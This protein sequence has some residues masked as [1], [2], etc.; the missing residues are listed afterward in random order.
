MYICFC[1]LQTE[2]RWRLTD[3]SET[4]WKRSTLLAIMFTV[5]DFQINSLQSCEYHTLCG[6]L[7]KTQL[8]RYIQQASLSAA[9]TAQLLRSQFLASLTCTW[10]ATYDISSNTCVAT[11]GC[12]KNTRLQKI[13][14]PFARNVTLTE[15]SLVIL[16][17]NNM[18]ILEIQLA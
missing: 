5:V 1:G 16:Q 13:T 2:P 11:K 6:I 14:I 15:R 9:W 12:F 18:E 4:T 3:S 10:L 8:E 17:R 7:A